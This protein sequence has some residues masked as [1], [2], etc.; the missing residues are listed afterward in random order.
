MKNLKSL[1]IGVSMGIMGCGPDTVNNYYDKNSSPINGATDEDYDR[2]NGGYTCRD[3][4]EAGYSCAIRVGWD[5]KDYGYSRE[6]SIDH[7][8]NACHAANLSQKCI[9]CV[10]STPCP[11][12]NVEYLQIEFCQDNGSCGDF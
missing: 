3:F 6:E 8:T 2:S 1:L 10:V 12:K 11:L 7:D 9:D 4:A 5:A